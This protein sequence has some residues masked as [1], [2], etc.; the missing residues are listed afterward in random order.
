MK[1]R[2]KLVLGMELRLERRAPDR[3]CPGAI[4]ADEKIS[5]IYLSSRLIPTHMEIAHI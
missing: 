1:E 2:W 5:S 3:R 4:P